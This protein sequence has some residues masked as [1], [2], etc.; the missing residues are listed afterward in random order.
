MR[1]VRILALL[2]ASVLAACASTKVTDVGAGHRDQQKDL[3]E[4]GLWFEMD[5]AEKTIA[6]AP[7]R[8]TDPALQKYLDQLNCKLAPDLCADIRVYLIRQPYFNAF[9]APNGMMVIFTGT[10]IR[11][12]DEA[13]LATVM[14]HEIGHYRGR[15][16]LENWRHLK[17]VSNLMTGISAFAGSG[18]SVI[19]A[20]GAYANL[21]SFSREQE[22]DAD[23][24]GFSALQA[25]KLDLQAPG[26][27]W[28]AAYEEEAAN[29]QG[30]LSGIFGSHP[31]T[32]ERRDR[33]TQLAHG[34][35][36]GDAGT[37]RFREA[38][39]NYRAAW[40]G[41]D[42]SR[43]N[44]AQSEVMLKRLAL[45][46]WDLAN[47][48]YFQGELYRK[49]AKPGDLERA[50]SAY[51]SALREPNVTPNVL[52]ELGTVLKRVGKTNA[53][54]DAFREY[55]KRAPQADDAAMIRSYLNAK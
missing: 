1:A 24:R 17:N 35:A 2:G 10:L 49:R 26:K 47:V 19:A 44:F 33:L 53:A 48:Y 34:A 54:M 20:F 45:I 41:D 51:Q 3:D 37:Q 29:P 23:T 22:R 8:I 50:I 15:H 25:A 55:L 5:R 4:A 14:A 39:Q 42:L 46:R 12:E 43:R 32:K 11:T 38:I 18:A 30:M 36:P 9:M 31:A 52:R 6:A 21:A 16:S 40:L 13:Q 27:L 7:E 28:S